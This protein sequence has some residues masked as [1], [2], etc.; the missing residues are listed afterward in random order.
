MRWE[1]FMEIP[2]DR[3]ADFTERGMGEAGLRKVPGEA[4]ARPAPG[5]RTELDG[6][7]ATVRDVL[8]CELC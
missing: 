7:P 8:F 5:H 3:S 1:E 4:L 2:V 6:L